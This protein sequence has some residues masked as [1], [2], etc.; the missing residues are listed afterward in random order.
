MKIARILNI[1]MALV[2]VLGVAATS[3]WKAT[4]SSHR[5]APMISQDP[6]A[7]NL[8]LYAF[9]SPDKPDTVSLI[10]TFIPFEGPAGGPNFYRFGD[11]V[12]Y[13]IY[14]DNDADAKPDITYNFEFTTKIMNPNTFLYNTGPIKSL[15][16]PNWNLRQYYKVTRIDKNGTTVLGENLASTPSNVGQHSTPNYDALMMAGVHSLSDG[17]MVFAGQSDDPFWVDVGAIFDLLSIRKLPGNA[18]GGI[19]VLYKQNA[20][21]IALQ[22]PISKLTKTGDAP[23]DAK[24]DGAIIGVWST[25]SRHATTVLNGGGKAP[26]GSGDWVQ[27]SR[28]GAPLVNEVVVPLGAKDLWNNSKPQDDAQFLAGV[29]DPELAKLL[30]LLFNID[31]P[32][33]P[34]NDLVAVFLT[35]VDGL[36]KPANVVPSE[37][38]RLN[39]AVKPTAPVGQGNI[40]GVV[41]GDLAGFPNGRR[42]EDDVTDIELRAVAGVL[43]PKFAISPNKD[44]GDGVDANEVAYK[45]SFPYVAT[46]WGGF[47]ATPNGAPPSA[48][49]AAP[50]PPAGAPGMPTTGS[51]LVNHLADIYGLLV[52]MLLLVG[53]ALFGGGWMLARRKA[54]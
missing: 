18:G 4:A 30:K 50:A 7:D 22:V 17:S 11:D 35:G 44:L 3:G 47:E 40:Y 9:V 5:E 27:V 34:R 19:D 2:V 6:E 32:P 37:E 16:D 1:V 31:S 33:A 29:T 52:A 49:L 10:A 25:T 14:V 21:A 23:S 39:V 48:P 12:L 36:T 41:G 15:D 8:D 38:L 28:L 20:H 46:A 26:T 42:L 13:T 51:P 43:D 24:A 54:N 45:T 53:A